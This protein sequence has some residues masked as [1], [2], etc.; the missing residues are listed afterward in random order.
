MED[1][2]EAIYELRDESGDSEL[3]AALMN[4]RSSIQ[5]QPVDLLHVSAD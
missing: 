1:M 3:L 2:E 4:E 5:Y